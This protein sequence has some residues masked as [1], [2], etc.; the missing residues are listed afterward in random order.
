MGQQEQTSLGNWIAGTLPR[1]GFTYRRRTTP[2]EVARFIH[3]DEFTVS[4]KVVEA[5][6]EEFTESFPV[7][8]MV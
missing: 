8:V 5:V 3:R 6:I 1:L 2:P 4:V 7:T